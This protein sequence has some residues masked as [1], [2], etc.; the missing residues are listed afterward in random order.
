MVLDRFKELSVHEDSDEEETEKG[1]SDA[2]TL[3]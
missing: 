2:G 3:N 1:T